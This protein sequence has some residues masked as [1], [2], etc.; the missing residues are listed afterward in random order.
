MKSLLLIA[1]LSLTACGP[2]VFTEPAPP[3]E[4]RIAAAANLATVFDAL[5]DAEVK[6][7]GIRLIPSFGS[8]AQLTQQIQAGAPFDVFLAADTEHPQT[9]AA[10]S[11]SDT[12][13]EYARGR[14][15]IW[16]PKHPDVRALAD[17]TRPDLKFIAVANPDLAPYGH[18]AMEALGKANVL[19]RI[20]PKLVFAQNIAAA[21]SYADTGNAD[22]ALT[23]FALVAKKHPDAPLVPDNLHAPIVQSLCILR[24]TNQRKAAEAFV[25]FV[26]GPEARAILLKN[27]YSTPAPAPAP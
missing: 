17:L 12:P 21:L 8:T 4:L 13:R 10:A 7:T 1:L 15:V 11:L 16:A 26:L 9:L 20:R 6:A 22:V 24:R 27:G 25:A 2:T 5:R 23:A 3:S 14:V 19:D 18:A